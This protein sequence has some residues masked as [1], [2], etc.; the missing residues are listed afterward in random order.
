MANGSIFK[1]KNLKVL[2]KCDFCALFLRRAFTS[3]FRI[4]FKFRGFAPWNLGAF[5]KFKA[6]VNFVLS[7][8]FKW[9]GFCFLSQNKDSY[10]LCVFIHAKQGFASGYFAFLRKLSMTNL[11]ESLNLIVC[12]A[13]LSQSSQWRRILSFWVSEMGENSHKLKKTYHSWIL[14]FA[15]YDKA[16][17]Q[18]DNKISQYNKGFVICAFIRKRF[19]DLPA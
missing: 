12:H 11:D 9:V 13:L 19:G 10:R 17:A 2:K 6:L 1:Q 7:Q 3:Y 15:Q 18:H 16:M 4:P 5:F 14:R 8:S